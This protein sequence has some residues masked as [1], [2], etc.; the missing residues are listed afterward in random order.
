MKY[1]ISEAYFHTCRCRCCTTC[2]YAGFRQRASEPHPGAKV[3]CISFSGGDHFDNAVRALRPQI[4]QIYALRMGLKD[5]CGRPWILLIVCFVITRE[6]L[7]GRLRC[8]EVLA[9]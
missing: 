4:G 1:I 9:A 3:Y 2:S 8:F 7:M 5:A 6:T